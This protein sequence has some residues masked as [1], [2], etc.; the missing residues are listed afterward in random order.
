MIW[1][2][3]FVNVTREAWTGDRFLER[4]RLFIGTRWDFPDYRWEVGYLNQYIPRTN[5]DVS[6][7]SLVV[8]LFF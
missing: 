3:P 1:S 4:H 8:Y 7:H 2:E 5:I 6:E